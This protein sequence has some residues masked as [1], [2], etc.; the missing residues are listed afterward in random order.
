M[1]LEEKF[2]TEG[3]T[4]VEQKA[5]MMYKAINHAAITTIP[6]SLKNCGYPRDVGII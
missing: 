6:T 5:S 4:D 3:E 1:K 2:R